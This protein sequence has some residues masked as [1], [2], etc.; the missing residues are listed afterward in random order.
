MKSRHV[1]LATVAALIVAS[2][3]SAQEARVTGSA[4]TY[5]SRPFLR[6]ERPAYQ[7]YAIDHFQNYE[8]HNFPYDDSRRTIYGPMG[9]YLVNGY[10]LYSWEENRTPGQEYGSAIFKPNEMYDLPWEKVYNSTAVTKDGYGNWGFQRFRC[11]QH[12]SAAF[13]F[14]PVHGRLQRRPLGHVTATIQEHSV[15]F[16]DRAAPYLPRNG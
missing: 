6:W 10:D 15:G 1:W 14:D 5:D 2:G 8:N 3:T 7:N 12:D 4:R 13:L 16:P 11:R 9:D